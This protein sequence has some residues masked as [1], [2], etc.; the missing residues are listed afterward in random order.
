[1]ASSTEWC[2]SGVAVAIFCWITSHMLAFSFY[3]Y[4][5]LCS[6]AGVRDF[7]FNEISN[8]SILN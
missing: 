2:M 4:S 3:V 6:A 1:M 7:I 8:L 5:S